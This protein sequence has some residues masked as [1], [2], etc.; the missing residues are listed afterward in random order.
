MEK[1]KAQEGLRWSLDEQAVGILAGMKVP[2]YW[3]ADAVTKNT[4]CEDDSGRRECDSSCIISAGFNLVYYR[5]TTPCSSPWFI[6]Q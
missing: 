4:A 2:R 1:L 3:G 6:H 5:L